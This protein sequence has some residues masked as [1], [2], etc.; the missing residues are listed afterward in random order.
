MKRRSSITEHQIRSIIYEE[1]IR[2]HLLEEGIWDDVKDGVKKLS[3][4]V[5]AKF[6]SMA[7]EWASTIKEKID[8]LSE[9]PKDVKVMVAAL[10][11]AMAETGE[12][13]ELNDELKLAKDLG[14]SDALAAATADLQGGV[15]AAAEALQV[16]D[17]VA[18][19]YAVLSNKGYIRQRKKLH[20]MGVITLA[21]FGLALLGGLPMLFK[22]LS[23]IAK[24]LHAEKLSAIFKKAEHVFH[25]IEEKVVDWIVPDKLA[26]AVYKFLGKKGFHVTKN[27]T[28]LP[29][30]EFLSDA[31]GDHAKKKTEALLYKALL[32]FFALNGL[33]G[34]LH[35]G[36]SILGFVEGAAT[37]VKGVELATGAAEIGAIITAA[38][39]AAVAV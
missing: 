23:R 12:S 17:T 39:G 15:H 10:K 19:V 11:A 28:I 36:A 32:I 37:A 34:I 21:G 6:K 35:A 30:E 4:Q 3:A 27:Q 33:S 16:G 1:M 22:G 26:Y 5:T 8:G 31:G 9:T 20:E 38:K 24:F 13:I 2:Q 29:Y 14:K 25:H 7:A 18:E